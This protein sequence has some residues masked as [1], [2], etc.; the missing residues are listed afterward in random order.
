M[1]SSYTTNLANSS[2]STSTSEAPSRQPTP[3]TPPRNASPLTRQPTH[4]R[5]ASVPNYSPN[6]NVSP[7][8]AA[9]PTPSPYNSAHR[10]SVIAGTTSLKKDD[11]THLRNS[12]VSHFRTLSR[13]TN[14]GNAEEFGIVAGA[15]ENVAG[16]HGRKR[17]Q[18]AQTDNMTSWERMTWMD[19]RRQY[20][21]AY[22]YL[23]HIGEAKEWMEDCI[24]EPIPPIVELEE[25]LRNG[26]ALAKLTRIFS[27]ELVPRIFEHP[28][29]QF[30]HSDNI[31]RFFRFLRKVELPDI[32]FFETTDLYNKKNIP[33]VIYC[34]H[35]LSFLLFRLGLASHAVGNLVGK[36]EF[37]ETEIQNT[38]KGLDTAGVS[39]PAFRGVNKHFEVE[40]EPEP[41]ETEEERITRELRE[42][43]HETFELQC[44]CR[45]AAVRL[46]LGDM[47][48]RL[49]DAEEEILDLQAR[50]RGM[51]CRL[52]FQYRAD[53]SRW[54]TNLQAISR[55]YLARQRHIQQL[56]Y[57]DKNQ[58]IFARLQ[59][60]I[61]ANKVREQ[62]KEQRTQLEKQ[63]K[64]VAVVQ[65]VIRGLLVRRRLGEQVA[66]ALE[67]E[68][69]VVGL[70]ALAKGI[71]A[72]RRF[73]G[74]MGELRDQEEIFTRLQ[75]AVRGRLVRS[76]IHQDTTAL[77]QAQEEFAD[78]AAAARG[79]LV[80]REVQRTKEALAEQAEVITSRQ[81]A[82]RGVL[83]RRQMQQTKEALEEQ[84]EDDI[85][86][87]QACAQGFLVRSA[88][89]QTLEQLDATVGGVTALQAR[90]RGAL[91]RWEVLDTN[92]ALEDEEESI[93]GLQAHARGFLHR[94]A[95]EDFLAELES[96]VA[97]IVDVQAAARG[98]LIRWRLDDIFQTKLKHYRDNM[99]KVIKLQSF[100]RA[101]QQGEAY[102]SLM[103]GKNPPVG[104][105]KNF[106]HLLNDS[107]FDFDEEIEFEGLR[108]KVV[109]HVRANELAEAYVDQLDVKIA[110]LVK[111][112]I[113]LD[114][115]IKHQKR[116]TGHVGNLLSNTD[117]ASSDPFDLKALNNNSRKRLEKYQQ[118]FYALQTQPQ[119]LSRLFKRIREQNTADKELKRIENLVMGIFG[120][121]QK[122]REEFYLLKLI[123]RSVKEEIDKCERPEDFLRAN[124]FWIK[125]VGSYIRSPRDRKF[126]HEL[127]G[128][129]VREEFIDNEELDLESD[130]LQIYRASI[131][132]EELQTGMRSERNPDVGR[133]QAIRDPETRETFIAH[134][135]ALRTLSEDFM[136]VLDNNVERMPY[137]IR[138][139]ARKAIEALLERFPEENE[140][141]IV[142]VVEHFV[143]QKYFNPAIIGPDAFGIVNKTLTPIQ[144]KNLGALSKLLNQVSSGRLF[145]NENMFLQPL[146][147][148][149]SIAIG[150]FKEVFKA[151][152]DVPTVEARF[153]MDEFED[154]TSKQKPT[155]YMKMSDIF[156]IHRL[157]A[158]EIDAIAETRE[159]PLRE[160]I[161]ELGSVQTSESELKTVG[162]TE[163]SL[164]LDPSFHVVDDPES[165]IKA[166]FVETKR[167]ILYIIRIQTG[168]N[169]MEILVKPITAEDEER[170]DSL[171]AEELQNSGGKKRGAYADHTMLTDINSMSYAQLKRTA[172]ENIINLE[173]FGKITRKNQYQDILNQ[174]AIDIR[175][176]HR[177][178]VQRSREME[179][180]HQTLA[181]LQEK[182][183]YLDQQ[184]KSYNDYIEQAMVTLQTKKGKKKTILPFTRQYF[185]MRELERSG[186]VPKFGS[187]KYSARALADKGV[188]VKLDGYP[189]KRWDKINFTIASDEIGSFF[190][191]ASNGSMMIP[192]ASAQVLLDDLLQMQ[193]HNNQFMM[194]CE[195]MIKFNVNL[196]LHLLFRK[197]YR[198]E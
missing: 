119:Y 84:A 170:W 34:I 57:C 164:Q 175:T 68:D 148:Y 26:V 41:E 5:G 195:G 116:F 40:P 42:A 168:T 138:Y 133:D 106:V 96:H 61:R 147:E 112:K 37:T 8:A 9:R 172:L 111:N 63:Q 53:M 176:K 101:K 79:V 131:N 20:I 140:D 81:A 197:F 39:L 24:G 185:H 177:R 43:R 15:S 86:D 191:E 121:S 17:L 76:R 103:G 25:A 151:I 33:K 107:D 100:V 19:K 69:H 66:D 113:T 144:K 2:S 178:R 13:L 95:R 74:L 192:G 142:Q 29:L 165:E 89:H 152:V 137:G 91:V 109:Q 157:V 115:V 70:Q 97:D 67:S 163:I 156:A 182:A 62:V 28:K 80:R 10:N 181:H 127:L 1:L 64:G 130:P 38:Q 159:D 166:L 35:A 136:N 198:D 55:G 99:D 149:V 32:F 150:Q 4:N 105:V 46:R 179:G 186:R 21:Q 58:K 48:D 190:V 36:L 77:E 174:I 104:T 183:V 54:A 114:E 83:V 188:L 193:F 78:L 180:I 134:L 94:L 73:A 56:R 158:Q 75:S 31:D 92:A 98:V 135:Q 18:R 82:A 65:S 132:N 122:R 52:S 153:E 187:Y 120:Y 72:R 88:Y 189:E 11:I 108:K 160:I 128:P 154:L 47:M 22:E 171:V 161:N 7:T 162:N 110:L 124:F 16:M 14:E 23:C 12:S 125:L 155:L 145:A 45:G 59:A 173:R 117:I 50:V 141:V 93:V 118:M 49:W 44:L 3:L 6:P 126:L 184:L 87:I 71:L 102:K 51:F 139:I 194:L 146:N 30:R 123:V 169:L 90:C 129:L 143:F 27:P 85:V 196:F 167:C 60:R